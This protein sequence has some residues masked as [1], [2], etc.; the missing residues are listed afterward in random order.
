MALAP[1][2][3]RAHALFRS[4]LVEQADSIRSRVEIAEHELSAL[5]ASYPGL[6][7]EVA[8]EVEGA[9]ERMSA[10]LGEITRGEDNLKLLRTALGE[11]EKREGAR[12]AEVRAKADAARRRALSQHIGRIRELAAQYQDT[13]RHQRELWDQI[14]KASD[15]AQKLLGGGAAIQSARLGPSSLRK[16]IEAELKRAAFDEH[17]T[18]VKHPL[19]GASKPAVWHMGEQPSLIDA[20][21]NFADH[22]LAEPGTF[23]PQNEEALEDAAE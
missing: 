15:K 1:V 19:P 10:L 12:L 18:R 4:K 23:E 16:L 14:L 8:S 2:V 20:V 5:R 9:A 6:A 3:E 22:A 13:I 17:P 21:A 11:A 7:Y